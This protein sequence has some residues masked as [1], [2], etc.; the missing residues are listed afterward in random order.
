MAQ[1]RFGTPGWM[2]SSL[3]Q[4]RTMKLY[5]SPKR[6][7]RQ[8]LQKNEG[9]S[10]IEEAAETRLKSNRRNKDEGLP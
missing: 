2:L 3:T 6:S 4:S 10:A 8:N 7:L 9:G 5:S 1:D